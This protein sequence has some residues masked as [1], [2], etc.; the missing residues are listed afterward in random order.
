[1]VD[2]LRVQIRTRLRSGALLRVDAA[3]THAGASSGTHRCAACDDVIDGPIEFRLRFPDGRTLR[4]HARCRDV[5]LSER[6]ALGP[7]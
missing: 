6:D 3:S 4:F 1:V 2:T 5:W 7:T